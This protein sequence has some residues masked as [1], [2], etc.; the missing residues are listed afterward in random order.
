MKKSWV[1][2]VLSFLLV[3]FISN[4]CEASEGPKIIWQKALGGSNDDLAYSI[5][6]TT[7][8]YIVAGYTRSNDGDV[9][10]N[11]GQSDFWIVKLGL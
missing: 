5:Q 9:R 10:E 4:Y 11:H 2:F 6:Q 1:M 7:D 8:G 3:I